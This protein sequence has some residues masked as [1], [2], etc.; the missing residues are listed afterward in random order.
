V[1]ADTKRQVIPSINYQNPD[2]SFTEFVSAE[3]TPNGSARPETR[4]MDCMDCHNRPTH[5]FDMP[6]SALNREMAAGRINSSLPF[7]HK[8]SVDLL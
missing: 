2:G 4:M 7:V 5:T 8:V 6:E 1:A 3:A